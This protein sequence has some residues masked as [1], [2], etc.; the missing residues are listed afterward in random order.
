MK[1]M[2]TYALT[3][4]LIIALLIAIFHSVVPSATATDNWTLTIDSQV[5]TGSPDLRE[6]VWQKNASMP[7]N[8]QYDRIGLHRLIKPGVLSKGAIFIDPGIYG[9]G[10]QLLSNPPSGNY[11]VNENSSQGIYWANRGFEVY[12]IDWRAHFLPITMN[13]SQAGIFAENWGYAQYINDMKEAVDKAK[14]LSG[15]SKIFL[16]GFSWGG[17]VALFY[18]SQYWQQ[19]LKG[20]I[21]L[22]GGENT[23]K[24]TNVTNSINATMIIGSLRAAGNL[25]FEIPRLIQT[26]SPPGMLFAYQNALQN[27]GGPAEWPAGTP[28]Q[29]AVNPLTNKTWTNITEYIAY[30]M[31][32]IKYSNIYAGYG[33]IS[34]IVKFW[35]GCDRYWPARLGAEQNALHDWNNCSFVPYDFDDHY[36]EINVPTLTFRTG[37]WGIPTYGNYTNGLATTDFSQITLPNYGHLDAFTGVYS[38]R[39][40]SEPAYQWI[41]NHTLTASCSSS[42]ASVQTGQSATIS[43]SISGG[44][45][46]YTYQWFEGST[47]LTGQTAAQL[48]MTKTTPGTY[49]YFCRV[50]DSIGGITNS[51][52]TTLIVVAAPT[53]TPTLAATPTATPVPTPT[54]SPTFIATSTPRATASPKPTQ[55]LTATP[56]PTPTIQP[57]ETAQPTAS[58][59]SGES[60]L[61]VGTTYVIVAAVVV[62]VVIVACAVTIVLRRRAN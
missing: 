5:V 7:P 55:A 30:Q 6:Y 60:A 12:S 57:T 16:A 4:L 58:P 13:S 8:T 39:D 34:A 44:P 47:A 38:A 50:N 20:L 33:N 51:S 18:A 10:E 31:Y 27:P 29:P 22:D 59:S 25:A 9:S 45:A 42:A 35:A 11:S 14:E 62:C 43:V 61:S 46:P 26:S 32:S 37:M 52:V 36:K 48:T 49:T 28:L 24:S 1:N 41:L 21:L 56:S 3:T 2:K 17:L 23:A 40:V 19:D 15:N 54:P 53:P